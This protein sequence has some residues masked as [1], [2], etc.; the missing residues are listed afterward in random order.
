MGQGEARQFCSEAEEHPRSRGGQPPARGGSERGPP[1]AP[2]VGGFRGVGLRLEL[3]LP[4]LEAS[5]GGSVRR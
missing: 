4:L 1:G 5:C 3:I 2:A